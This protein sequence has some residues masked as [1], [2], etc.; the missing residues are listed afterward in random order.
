MDKMTWAK[1]HP[2]KT[3]M[4]NSIPRPDGDINSEVSFNIL[5]KYGY[6]MSSSTN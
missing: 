5:K 4:A 6:V 2:K 1:F 3:R